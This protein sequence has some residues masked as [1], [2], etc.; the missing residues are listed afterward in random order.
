MGDLHLDRP[1]ISLDKA[2]ISRQSRVGFSEFA[3]SYPGQSTFVIPE[4]WNS[5]NSNDLLL[6]LGLVK[7]ADSGFPYLS[8][9]AVRLMNSIK[10][11]IYTLSK[12]EGFFE[13]EFPDVINVELIKKSGVYDEY[14]REVFHL[15]GGSDLILTATSEE[16]FIEYL[17]MLDVNSYRQLPVKVFH[18][19]SA[20]RNVPRARGYYSTKQINAAIFTHMSDSFE[21]YIDCM[22]CFSRVCEG[23]FDNMGIDFLHLKSKSN[24][25]QE[26]FYDGTYSDKR[27][28]DSVVFSRTASREEVVLEDKK[29]ASIAMSYPYE[30][31]GNF[32]LKIQDGKGSML[33]PFVGTCGI[34]MQRVLMSLLDV[35]RDSLGVSFPE[36]YRPWDL[37]I[38]QVSDSN[39]VKNTVNE[40]L[41]CLSNLGLNILVDD[42]RRN[43]NDKHKVSDFYGIPVKLVVGE[44]D[45]IHSFE[46][47]LRGLREKKT[48]GIESLLNFY[49]A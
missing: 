40:L 7:F 46:F 22:E 13:V 17:R 33:S 37:S 5:L 15:D 38:I 44:R 1:S 41:E 28:G 49:T 6:K 26:F 20:F 29:M 16:A 8:P 4:N 47:K 36:R 34:G 12:K 42:R 2:T 18:Y 48:L 10:E 11:D 32:D 14:S 9:I 35:H 31:V 3:S 19:P 21:G 27:V 39:H 43:I 24:D 30:K 23:L 45:S 25:A